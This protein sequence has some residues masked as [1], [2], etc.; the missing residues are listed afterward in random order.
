MNSQKK[1]KEKK[2]LNGIERSCM[3]RMRGEESRREKKGEKV[4]EQEMFFNRWS[5]ETLW[6]KSFD[7]DGDTQPLVHTCM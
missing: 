5:A 6:S 3:H 7:G 1:R 2:G 4:M